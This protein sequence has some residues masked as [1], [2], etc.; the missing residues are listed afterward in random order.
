MKREYRDEGMIARVG[1]RLQ[2]R[3]ISLLNRQRETKREIVAH[4]VGQD[5]PIDLSRA[6]VFPLELERIHDEL[7]FGARHDAEKFRLLQRADLDDRRDLARNGA[8]ASDNAIVG[9]DVV[10]R[11][12]RLSLGLKRERRRRQWFIGELS[13][14][15]RGF[16]FPGLDLGRMGTVRQRIGRRRRVV[17]VSGH[18]HLHCERASRNAGEHAGSAGL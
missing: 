10:D 3:L 2:H 6:C 14:G 11:D 15:T 5:E 9:N 18:G 12:A 13:P 8:V 7:V 1:I 16:A 4:R 17:G